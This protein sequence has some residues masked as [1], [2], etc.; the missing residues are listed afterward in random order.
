MSQFN[1]PS[2]MIP[3]IQ[4][5]FSN[6]YLIPGYT[7]KDPI[8]LDIGANVGAFS[9]WAYSKWPE[10]TIH[11]YE[12][13]PANFVYLKD[14]THRLLSNKNYHIYNLAVGDTKNNKL[15]LGQHNCGEC[16]FYQIGEQSNNYI[17][18]DTIS[19]KE[20]P[21]ANILKIDTEGSELDILRQISVNKFDAITFEY[22]RD[23]DRKAID[24]ML[25][26]FDLVRGF[27]RTKDRGVLTYVNQQINL[28]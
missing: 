3:H 9:I 5:V 14:N 21:S 2:E 6:E 4:Q 26:K 25:Y 27:I 18:V 16:S 20:L 15:Y 19:P 7:R 23:S 8:I 11:C 1:C 22:H 24:K 13:N 28:H 12:P 10:A 17:T